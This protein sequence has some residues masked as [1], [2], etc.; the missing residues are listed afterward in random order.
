MMFI[1]ILMSFS[2]AKKSLLVSGKFCSR[3]TIK[4]PEVE[5][6]IGMSKAVNSDNTS[7]HH[8][9]WSVCASFAGMSMFISY[10][11]LLFRHHWGKLIADPWHSHRGERCWAGL[12]VP[13]AFD[14]FVPWLYWTALSLPYARKR[15]RLVWN[16]WKC[17]FPK[18]LIRELR[19]FIV[20][21]KVL[22][23]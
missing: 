20:F 14:I 22:S 21:L 4:V 2:E 6:L 5:G 13:S 1:F 15:S 12:C 10:C 9:L 7:H 11:L 18:A 3:Y 17:L 23:T 8:G 19:G 16:D